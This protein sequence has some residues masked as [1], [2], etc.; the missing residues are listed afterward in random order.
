[1]CDGKQTNHAS[2][3]HLKVDGG[4]AGAPAVVLSRAQS[5]GE[6]GEPNV[7]IDKCLS[8]FLDVLQAVA[9]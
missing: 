7:W 1:M 5:C 9:L 8:V 2:E 3:G 4:R 6:G